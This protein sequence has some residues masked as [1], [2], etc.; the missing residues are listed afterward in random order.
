MSLPRIPGPAALVISVLCAPPNHPAEIKFSVITEFGS[1]AHELGPFAFD[2]T[3]YYNKEFGSGI[4]RWL[5]A[6]G[7]LVDRSKLVLI[8][9]LTNRIEQAYTEGGKRRYNLDPG[10][11]T[12]A[13]FV[14]A[15]GKDNAHRI[16]LD[17]GIFADLTLVYSGG[18][19]RPLAWTYPDY[20]SPEL[21]DTLNH[22]R[23]S[24]KCRLATPAP[25]T[26]T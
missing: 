23:E 24:Y 12:L 11:L 18:T 16:Y 17:A 1:I 19:Y 7:G 26:D 5:W 13:N 15:T 9:S 2:F 25:E 4:Q 14:L 21:I 10:L 20:A 6:F 3:T 22:L 8:K